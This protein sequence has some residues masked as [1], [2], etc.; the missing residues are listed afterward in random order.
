MKGKLIGVL[1]VFL[2]GLLS[3]SVVSAVDFASGK[4]ADDVFEEVEIDGKELDPNSLTRLRDYDRGDT[5]ELTFDIAGEAFNDTVE[6]ARIEAFMRGDS[7]GDDIEDITDRF[8]I[9][10][11]RLLSKTLELTLPE[12]MDRDT[13]TL[14]LLLTSRDGI[15]VTQEYKISIASGGED[16]KM[17]VKDTI[18]SPEGEV[19]AGRSLLAT[20]KVENRGTK[21]EDDVKVKVAIPA[22]GVSASAF[23]DEV[24][25]EGEDDD[26]VISEELYMRIPTDALTGDYKVVVSVEY[27]DGDEVEEEEYMIHVD[28]VSPVTDLEPVEEAKIQVSYIEAQDLVAGE[29]GKMYPLTIINP[30]SMSKTV[31]IAVDGVDAF[32]EAVVEPSNVVI[33]GA[34]ETKLVPVYVS[35]D[36]D[37][38]GDYTFTVTLSGLTDDD[39]TVVMNADVSAPEV[40]E[41]AGWDN[42]KKGLQIALLVLVVLLV[43]LGLI[44]GFGKL[45]SNDEEDDEAQTYY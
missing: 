30:T 5:L 24:E 32:G 11:D 43:L 40:P 13:Y 36:A 16:H 25:A 38:E 14:S 9:H 33:V 34:G 6:D 20:V 7:H 8:D 17:I 2:I 37:A 21:D 22:L 1:A 42:V 19:K 10:N 28:G 45:R 12:R 35:A 39:Q 29:A 44:I 31:V 3:L 15:L 4:T 26:I 41:N 23:I 18:F 27:D